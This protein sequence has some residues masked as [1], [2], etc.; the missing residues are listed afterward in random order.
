MQH[1]QV[2]QKATQQQ[3]QTLDEFSG[4][5]DKYR[6]NPNALSQIYKIMNYKPTPQNQESNLIDNDTMKE[7]LKVNKGT[8]EFDLY[9]D[10]LYYD[11][12][13]IREVVLRQNFLI[14]KG[15]FDPKKYFPS[16][17]I[18]DLEDTQFDQKIKDMLHNN[19]NPQN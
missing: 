16:I 19:H 9:D 14:S 15:Y 7:F 12:N 10:I 1:T 4:L 13:K 3:Q 18:N 2:P 6:N 8:S 11:E 17:Q 5:L